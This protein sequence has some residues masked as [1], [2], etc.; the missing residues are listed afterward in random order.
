M[1]EHFSE[2]ELELLEAR[3]RRLAADK[4]ETEAAL[5]SVLLCFVGGERYA[6]L[7][8]ELTAIYRNAIVVPVPCAPSFLR[9]VANVRGRILPVLGLADVL[10]IPK[11]TR[12]DGEL[13]VV[14]YEGHLVALLVDRVD[15]VVTYAESELEIIP[16]EVLSGELTYALPDGAPVL[17]VE[18]LLGDPSLLIDV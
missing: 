14:S 15:N 4:N 17:H 2:N 7:L 16:H 18:P 8:D 9:G 13:V 1:F 6:F 11:E 3:A 12:R 5:I 10:G